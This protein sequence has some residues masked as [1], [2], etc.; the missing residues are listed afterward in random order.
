VFG[1]RQSYNA[2]VK[3]VA[4]FAYSLLAVGATSLNGDERSLVEA[5]GGIHYE[6]PFLRDGPPVDR[7][8]IELGA[9]VAYLPPEQGEDEENVIHYRVGFGLRFARILWL[10]G[11]YDVSHD[12]TPYGDDVGQGPWA[13]LAIF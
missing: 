6:P 9:H 2:G 1:S 7:A 3:S 11:G 13:G 10:F 4:G 5:G 8:A 12:M